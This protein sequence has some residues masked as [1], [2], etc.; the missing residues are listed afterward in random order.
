[1]QYAHRT[2]NEHAIF[3]TRCTHRICGSTHAS[4]C[5]AAADRAFAYLYSRTLHLPRDRSQPSSSFKVLHCNNSPGNGTVSC[6]GSGGCSP[7]PTT[8]LAPL[9]SDV[10]PARCD[11]DPEYCDPPSGRRPRRIVSLQTLIRFIPA[12]GIVTLI[13]IWGVGWSLESLELD[14]K[15]SLLNPLTVA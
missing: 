5:L 3:I 10:V 9:P 1:M 2:A 15:P 4:S 13:N 11:P 6:R 7:T 14:Q 8:A 12:A